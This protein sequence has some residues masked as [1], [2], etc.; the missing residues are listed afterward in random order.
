VLLSGSVQDSARK[1][2]A[3]AL[4]AISLACCIQHES[5]RDFMKAASPKMAVG[6][7]STK[8]SLSSKN[9][10]HSSADTRLTATTGGGDPGVG[11]FM[12]CK[13]PFWEFYP[14]TSLPTI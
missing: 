10:F 6:Q 5:G 9:A 8:R 11:L 2:A 3:F 13:K 1:A 14:T 4:E 7:F 12:G